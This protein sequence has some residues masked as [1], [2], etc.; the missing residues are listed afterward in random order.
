MKSF[1]LRL[2][3]VFFLFYCSTNTFCQNLI[4]NPGA[5]SG[6]PTTNG[7]TS[8]S[9]GTTGSGCYNSSGWRI[10]QTAN[11]FPSAHG[12]SYIFFPGCSSTNGLTYELRQDINVSANASVIDVGWDGFTF[13]GYLQTYNQ[14]P[15]DQAQMIVEYRDA[16]NS[17]VITSYNTGLQTS[18]SA[19][20]NY[21]N[22]TV[23]PVGTRYIRIRLLAKVNTG[24][25]DD[26]YFDDLSLISSIPLPVTFTSV[27]LIPENNA[28]QINWQTS[29][30]TNNSYFTVQRSQDQ[31]SW[32]DIATV[33]GRIN[34]ITNVNYSVVDNNP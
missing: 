33:N 1:V 8:V 21:S 18:A 29:S 31:S 7:W 23:A 28:V 19:W 20:K 5:E 3:V 15:S 22:T 11:G 13:S 12:G 30:E 2:T 24:P 6:D 32:I 4:V 26:G 17:T 27:S 16:A 25:S 34:S 9:M 10:V 14:S